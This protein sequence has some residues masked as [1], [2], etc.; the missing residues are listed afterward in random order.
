MFEKMVYD[1]VCCVS[2]DVEYVE[3]PTLS[4]AGTIRCHTCPVGRSRLEMEE[5]QRS[6]WLF[7]DN[8]IVTDCIS[9]TAGHDSTFDNMVTI[10]PLRPSP[11]KDRP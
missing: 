8:D 5:Y 10:Y 1:A 4:R 2:I 6:E 11:Q 9:K 3:A 7:G